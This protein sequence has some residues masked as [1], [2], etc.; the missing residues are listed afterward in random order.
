MGWEPPLPFENCTNGDVYLYYFTKILRLSMYTPIFPCS[1]RSLV[2]KINVNYAYNLVQMVNTE[3]IT[4]IRLNK[5]NYFRK[6]R[7]IELNRLNRYC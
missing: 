4:L 3:T 5:N 6:V 2:Q 7:N 1:L